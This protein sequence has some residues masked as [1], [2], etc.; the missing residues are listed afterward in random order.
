MF[1]HFDVNDLGP[2]DPPF[3]S[4]TDWL[5]YDPPK[6]HRMAVQ[7]AQM[8]SLFLQDSGAGRQRY[9]MS[10]TRVAGYTNALINANPDY[11]ALKGSP[12]IGFARKA[13]TNVLNGFGKAQLSNPVPTDKLNLSS[14]AFTF[15]WADGVSALGTVGASFDN[16][17]ARSV[18]WY[19]LRIVVRQYPNVAGITFRQLS[20]DVTY[21]NTWYNRGNYANDGGYIP[22]TSTVVSPNNATLLIQKCPVGDVRIAFDSPYQQ[23]SDALGTSGRR[24]KYQEVEVNPVLYEYQV[25]WKR[26][27]YRI[28]ARRSSNGTEIR[29]LYAGRDITKNANDH[30]FEARISYPFREGKMIV[31]FGST[32]TTAPGNATISKLD[33][34]QLSGN[35]KIVYFRYDPD[36]GSK[37][38]AFRGRGTGEFKLNRPMHLKGQ[39]SKSANLSLTFR[40]EYTLNKQTLNYG[41]TRTLTLPGHDVESGP[42]NP[43]VPS[44]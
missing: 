27:G 9:A 17:A 13:L 14:H 32:Y 41:T 24:P 43:W 11:P 29:W 36:T 1:G 35:S 10:S 30:H 7:S 34:E 18:L 6:A 25:N 2:S 5:S 31:D 39:P 12:N 23:I 28:D 8:L 33:W 22:L 3:G 15:N 37:D 4:K 38:R 26:F 44:F 20:L 42:F 16:L 21:A 19:P 40:G